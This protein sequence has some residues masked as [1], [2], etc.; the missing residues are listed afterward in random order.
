VQHMGGQIQLQ[1]APGQGT[2][3]TVRLPVAP[4]KYVPPESPR[5]IAPP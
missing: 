1:S 4:R 3:F 5:P 2:R